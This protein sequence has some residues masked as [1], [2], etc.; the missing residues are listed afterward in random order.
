[1]TSFL[2]RSVMS[3]IAAR[4]L[5]WAAGFG[6]LAGCTALVLKALP[7]F[8]V[9]ASIGLVS[10]VAMGWVVLGTQLRRVICD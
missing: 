4:R 5:G 6:V 9:A 3:E 1:M 2:R 10:V 7:E 8:G